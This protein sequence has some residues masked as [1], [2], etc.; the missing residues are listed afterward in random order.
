VPIHYHYITADLTT[1]A[2]FEA[3]QRGEIAAEQRRWLELSIL[4]VIGCFSYL[5]AVFAVPFLCFF[6][7]ML[8]FMGNIP[9]Q[10]ISWFVGIMTVGA[11]VYSSVRGVQFR[12]E[13]D[14]VK[15]DLAGEKLALAEGQ[16]A[17][18]NG[19]YEF[20][21]WDL[22]LKVIG[23]RGGMAPGI[24]YRVYYLPES[25][26]ALS[27]QKI[28]ETAQL[29]KDSDQARLGLAEVLS[30]ALGY[31]LA[32]LEANRRGELAEDQAR[33]LQPA[34][35]RGALLALVSGGVA[36]YLLYFLF[37][38]T[39]RG[40][41]GWWLVVFLVTGGGL[42][43]FLKGVSWLRRVLSDL[44]SRRVTWV[45]GVGRKVVVRTSSPS[46]RTSSTRGI[47]YS[48]MIGERK[49]G[50]PPRLISV[51]IDGLRY[52]AYFTPGCESL[53]ALEPLESPL[54]EE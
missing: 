54:K 36:A 14:K 24:R 50:A 1:P 28:A 12:K 15:R 46:G 20:Q 26:V 4:S 33:T 10:I 52:R 25:L 6:I 30:Q 43:F 48:Y 45:D 5:G 2:F 37:S 17:Y 13:Q 11:L 9:G 18:R 47:S 34:L 42:Y 32:S 19:G 38:L 3:N 16:L 29:E 51:V 41:V 40:D 8:M 27:A 23:E 31:S 53:V 49:F 7:S 35:W 22:L 44:A 21:A 39:S